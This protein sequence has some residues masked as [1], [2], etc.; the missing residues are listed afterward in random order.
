MGN[1]TS[2]KAPSKDSLGR[3]SLTF[4]EEEEKALASVFAEVQAE[5]GGRN[6][7]LKFILERMGSGDAGPSMKSAMEAAARALSGTLMPEDGNGTACTLQQFRREVPC[8]GSAKQCRRAARN[9][10]HN[11]L[12]PCIDNPRAAVCNGYDFQRR[13]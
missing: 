6:G 7:L 11:G 13:L 4:H 3:D 8:S 12:L 9:N 1:S 2:G 10:A 5:G